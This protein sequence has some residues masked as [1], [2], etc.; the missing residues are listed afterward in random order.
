MKI[1]FTNTEIEAILV[2]HTKDLFASETLQEMR[3]MEFTASVPYSS[4]DYTVT[5][6][7]KETEDET[8]E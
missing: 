3:D 8:A 5:I 2:K 7:P 1:N 4:S 6:K